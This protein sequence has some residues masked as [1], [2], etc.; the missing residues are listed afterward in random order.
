MDTNDWKAKSAS[1]IL[2]PVAKASTHD[3]G[4]IILMH[5]RTELSF[6]SLP[7]VIHTVKNQGKRFVSMRECIGV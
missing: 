2:E 6:S 4:L 5:D 3:L 7:Q 1:E